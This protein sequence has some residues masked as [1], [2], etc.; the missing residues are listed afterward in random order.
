MKK[1][2]SFAPLLLVVAAIFFAACKKDGYNAS[3]TTKP[4]LPGKKHAPVA[5]INYERKSILLECSTVFGS[6]AIVGLGSTDQD[7]DIVLFAW[8]ELSGPSPIHFE[9]PNEASTYMDSLVAGIYSVELTVTDSSGL[10]SKDTASIVVTAA[11]HEYDLDLHFLSD[12]VFSND[13]EICPMG[14]RYADEA[15]I[16]ATMQIAP[17]VNLQVYI[18][19]ETDSASHAFEVTD[20][21]TG[22]R[23]SPQSYAGGSTSFNLKR[24]ISHGG[25]TFSGSI[26]LSNSSALA[27]C[28]EDSFT[29]LAPLKFT[30]TLDT[31]TRTVLCHLQGRIIF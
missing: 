22:F 14:C 19:E 17:S 7:N 15:F 2:I 1:N 6:T 24:I 25:G 23:V 30:G 12:Y 4:L 26:K 3:A 31:A 27:T 11:V 5:Q 18:R 21:Y 20:G 9:S 13:A 10:S 28:R 29:S 8:Q 16:S